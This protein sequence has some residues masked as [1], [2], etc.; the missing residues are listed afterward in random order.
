MLNFKKGEKK[1]SPTELSSKSEVLFVSSQVKFTGDFNKLSW[2]HGREL[3]FRIV[4][5]V[6]P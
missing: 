6:R 3:I 4:L 2:N 1:K 5:E